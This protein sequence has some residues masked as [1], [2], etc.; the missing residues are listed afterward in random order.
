M[1]SL[2]HTAAP[3]LLTSRGLLLCCT[4]GVVMG[5]SS[6]QKPNP[7]WTKTWGKKCNFGT[8][9]CLCQRLST[10]FYLFIWSDIWWKTFKKL[11]FLQQ[12]KQTSKITFISTLLAHLIMLLHQLILYFFN[13]DDFLK[14]S[15][16]YSILWKS[17]PYYEKNKKYIKSKMKK[18]PFCLKWLEFVLG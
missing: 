11:W 14:S 2:L 12:P 18:K 6:S 4:V 16:R 7:H 1:I 10:F 3:L 13:F 15:R 5:R 17:S 9:N 8:Y